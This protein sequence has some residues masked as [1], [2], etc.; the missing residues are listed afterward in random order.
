M[1]LNQHVI[2][3]CS[4]SAVPCPVF[5]WIQVNTNKS[6]P[7]SS[8]NSTC[9]TYSDASSTLNHTFEITDL[10]DY[11]RIQLVCIATNPYGRSEQY[12]TLSLNTSK[13]CS[14]VSPSPSITSP[15]PSIT[16]PGP[17]I[18][19]PGP[20]ITWENYANCSVVSPSAG[21]S[22]TWEYYTNSII[23]TTLAIDA[24]PTDFANNISTTDNAN[25]IPIIIIGTIVGAIICP[26]L[27]V[28]ILIIIAV[29]FHKHKDK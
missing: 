29:S 25:E 11:C 9:T 27:V 10:N 12:F 16:S 13:S 21:P 14:V 2:V 1:N 15:G 24:S 6:L 20:S 19:S 18:T 3:K 26:S 7:E 8:W 28:V 22:L 4:V 5:Q 17:S 23:T